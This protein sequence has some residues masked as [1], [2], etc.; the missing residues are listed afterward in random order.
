MKFLRAWLS[1]VRARERDLKAILPLYP[2]NRLIQ[3]LL[4]FFHVWSD[5]RQNRRNY[6]LILNLF[7]RHGVPLC[8][9]ALRLIYRIWINVFII[10]GICIL[11][12]YYVYYYVLIYV[13]IRI[14]IFTKF[15]NDEK[16]LKI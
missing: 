4:I 10:C 1:P 6:F 3:V 9:K 12:Y 15:T 2:L 16:D 5:S 14:Y 13:M 11:C 8:Y 7:M